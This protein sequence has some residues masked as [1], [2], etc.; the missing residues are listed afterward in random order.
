M[1]PFFDSTLPRGGDHVLSGP[2]AIVLGI[3]IVVSV[4]IAQT[5]QTIEIR[6][7]SADFQLVAEQTINDMEERIDNQSE[8]IRSIEI[9]RAHV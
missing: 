3:G 4:A 2:V 6:R 7:E 1:K 5:I 9:G 8:L